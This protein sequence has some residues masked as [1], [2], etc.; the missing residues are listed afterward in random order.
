MYGIIL[1]LS[2]LFLIKSIILNEFYNNHL[3]F[4]LFPFEIAVISLYN[5]ELSSH[6]TAYVRWIFIGWLGLDNESDA[7][8]DIMNI[9]ENEYIIICCWLIAFS[10]YQLY[11]IVREK[12]I[13]H[14][15]L[16]KWSLYS[17]NLKFAMINY[18][19]LYL[20]NLNTLVH[21]KDSKF[22]FILIN[23]LLFNAI[24]FW[25]PGI[26][27]NFIY[28]EKMYLY[29]IK[30]EFLIDGFHLK[31]KF[32]SIIL[33]ALKAFMG[34][35][36]LFF[37]FWIAGSKYFLLFVL[38]LYSLICYKINIFKRQ[39]LKYDILYQSGISVLIILLSIIEYYYPDNIEFIIFKIILFACYLSV[40]TYFVYRENKRKN[41]IEDPHSD[42]VEIIEMDTLANSNIINSYNHDIEV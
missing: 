42:C 11:Y 39:E 7:L 15:S 19:S 9:N 40:M 33:L 36:I 16:H 12:Y 23:L 20:W 31:Y 2:S 8:N 35:Y 26:L 37:N 1:L 34:L 32:F 24:T 25:F 13:N 5:P 3:I 30:Y 4:S 18:I 10:L 6:V 14:N 41:K 17:Y 21:V 27:F 38:G 22:W 28:G 29:R